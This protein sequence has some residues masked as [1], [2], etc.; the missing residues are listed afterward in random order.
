MDKD[1]LD[2][3]QGQGN[4]RGDIRGTNQG[5]T[6]GTIPIW[7]VGEDWQQ[8]CNEAD[9]DLAKSRGFRGQKGQIVLIPDQTNQTKLVLYCRNNGDCWDI[10]DLVQK[11][12]APAVYKIMTPLS[13]DEATLA[14]FVWAAASYRF[15]HYVKNEIPAFA[16][17]PL[18]TTT[19]LQRLYPWIDEATLVHEVPVFPRL[20]LPANADPLFLYPLVDGTALVRDLINSPTTKSG[21]PIIELAEKARDIAERYG[22]S[23]S[24]LSG[25]ELLENNFPLIHAV[26]QTEQPPRLV[27]IVWNGYNAGPKLTLIGSGTCLNSGG[28]ASSPYH[29]LRKKDMGGAAHALALAH[30]IMMVGLPVRL[31]VLIPIVEKSLSGHPIRLDV[32]QSRKGLSVEVGSIDTEGRLMLADA[33]TAACEGEPDLI[34]DCATLTNAAGIALGTDVPALF[35]NHED[36]IH[37][38]LHSSH[39]MQDPLWQLPLFHPYARYLQSQVADLSNVGSSN[40]GG[41]ITA[42]LFLEHFVAPGVPWIH[43]D[44]MAWNPITA[45]GR[46]EGGEAMGLRA[47]FHLV[48]QWTMT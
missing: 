39:I 32:L 9:V 4:I 30:M 44:M 24:V 42:A 43:V 2:I 22:A 13:N 37:K 23:Y 40:Y 46:P 19:N 1:D 26:E 34:I 3:K 6:K 7:F 14:A 12:P 27:E 48:H 41:A 36:W 21:G 38:L 16:Q 29:L 8:H 15:D 5:T 33:L 28:I 47:L 11:L 31:R 25:N 35:S 20:V 17:Q 18:P 45:P 10:A